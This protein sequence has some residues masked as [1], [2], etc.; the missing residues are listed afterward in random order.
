MKKNISVLTMALAMAAMLSACGSFSADEGFNGSTQNSFADS[1]AMVAT[2]A[3]AE[4]AADAG[5]GSEYGY[6]AETSDVTGGAN[7]SQI[8]TST[9]DTSRKLI[10]TV[11]MSTET[12]EF[13]RVTQEIE[14]KVKSLNGYIESMNTY[15]GS[16][17]YGKSERHADYTIRIPKANLDT[18]VNQ[19]SE[20]SNVTNKSEN[21]EDVTLTYVDIDSRKKAL[22]VEQ[23]RLLELLE[24]A[25]SVEDIITIESRLSDIRY[26]IQSIESQ[27]RTYDNQVDYSTV[28]LNVQEVIDYTVVEEESVLERMGRGFMESLHDLGDSIVDMAVWFV[29]NIPYL[30]VIAVIIF[31]IIFFSIRAGR[32]NKHR[33]KSKKSKEDSN[34]ENGSGESDK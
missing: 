11:N 17:Y 32:K 21:V 2:E 27:L 6:E 7:E 9:V 25:E 1:K 13:E 14:A 8:D 26:Q 5:W 4:A 30:L 16:T 20:A 23:D 22:L 34:A 3:A 24:K 12:K 15:N 18:F 28:Y 19:V 33:Q 31:L 10:R 29:V